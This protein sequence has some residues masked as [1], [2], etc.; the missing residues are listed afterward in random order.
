MRRTRREDFP[1]IIEL[2]R[3]ILDRTGAWP[4]I[5]ALPDA[6]RV[7]ARLN[8]YRFLD[9]AEDWSPLEGGP[10]LDAFLDHLD[11]LA[12]EASGDELDTARVSGEDAVALLTVHRAKGLEWPLVVLP[13]LADGTFP[14]RVIRYEDPVEDAT[15]LPRDLRL[16][17]DALPELG[18]ARDERRSVLKAVHDDA[19][20]RTAYVAVTRAAQELVAT[21]AW[22][23]TEGRPKRR[24]RLFEIVDSVAERAPDRSDEPGEPPE[25]LRLRVETSSGPDPH[26]PDGPAGVLRDAV[27]DPQIPRR[28]AEERGIAAQYDAAVDQLRIELDGLPAPPEDVGDDDRFRTS[29]TGLVT[30]AGCPL[31][32]RWEHLDRLPRRPSAAA[33]RGVEFHRRVELHHR[34]TVAFDDATPDFYDDPEET[35]TERSESAFDRFASSRFADDRPFLVEAPF[36]LKVGDAALSGRI[37][38]VYRGDDGEWEIV[39]FKSGR[40]VDDPA[41]RVQL[42]AYAV[43]AD[44]AGLG[45]A[46][47]PAATRVTFAY[48]GGDEVE[49]VSEPVDAAWLER[50]REHLAALM[51]GARSG[52]YDPVPG[53]RC[54]TCDFVRFCEPG[55]EYLEAEP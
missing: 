27:S 32:F 39:D 6:A 8:T 18:D 45:G 25:T 15:V 19:E 51:E 31:R 10:S 11:V 29:V 34:G 14:S 50:A 16:D 26:F 17:S 49:E 3:R 36:E 35:P 7:S 46:E 37:D 42:E 52:P 12:D 38:A 13:A 24:S 43:A 23:Y 55:A 54:H 5:D 40:R 20:W 28:I 53:P 48:F 33:R 41:R 1:Q 9:L 47:S 21:G 22:W 2:C 44:E 4:E 30:Y